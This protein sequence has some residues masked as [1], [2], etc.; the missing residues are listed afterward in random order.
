MCGRYRL[1]RRKQIIEEHFL[2]DWDD[3]AWHPRYNIAPTQSV[4]IIRQN[5]KEPVSEISSVRGA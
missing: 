4:P 2:A 5:P 3:L 1:S